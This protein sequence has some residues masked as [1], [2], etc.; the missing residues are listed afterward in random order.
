MPLPTVPSVLGS[1]S[2]ICAGFLR[3]RTLHPHL[4]SHGVGGSQKYPQRQLGLVGPVAPQA[5]G[6]SC[7]AQSSQEEAEVGCK[8]GRENV[9]KGH[10][11]F[12][13]PTCFSPSQIVTHV[14]WCQGRIC[15]VKEESIIWED[16]AFFLICSFPVLDRSRENFLK[17]L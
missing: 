10:Q 11:D 9:S 4:E 12:Q 7:H 5:M 3:Q 17:K 15:N 14:K 16:T 2:V 8:T 1:H 13:H 6:T